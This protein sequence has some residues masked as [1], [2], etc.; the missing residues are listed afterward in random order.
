M[1]FR[2]SCKW[3][4]WVAPLAVALG[5]LACPG[6]PPRPREFARGDTAAVQPGVPLTCGN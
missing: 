5:L 4:G 6:P 3:L 1:P 2:R